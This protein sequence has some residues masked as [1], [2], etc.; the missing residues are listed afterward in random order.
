MEHA[1]PKLRI[2]L[3]LDSMTIPSWFGRMLEIINSSDYA[4][5]ELVVL[6]TARKHY[7]LPKVLNFANQVLYQV[8]CRIEPLVFRVSPDAFVRRDLFD[9]IDKNTPVVRAEPVQTRHSRR[10]EPRDVE[11]IRSYDIDVLIRGGSKILRGDILKAAR[12]GVWSFHH[13]DNLRYRG[14]PPGFWE[15]FEQNPVTGTILQILTEDLDNGVVLARSYSATDMLSVNRNCNAIYWKSLSM[16]PR[17]LR[18]LHEYGED[19]FFSNVKAFNARPSFY[20]YRMY[21]SPT[22]L[23]FIR[24]ILRHIWKLTRLAV[25]VLF[26][27]KQWI[28]MYSPGAQISASFRK[29]KHLIPPRDRFWADP[30]VVSRNGMYYIFIEELIYREN[31]GFI[32]VIEMDGK[33][34]W[35]GPTKVLEQPYH[36]SY[37]FVF[38][39]DGSFYMVPETKANKTIELYKC[40]EFPS[41]WEK[42]KVLMNDVNAVDA[43]LFHHGDKWWMFVNIV[44][45]RGASTH[46]ELFLFYADTPLSEKWISHPMN[47]VISDA[48]RARPAGGI[49]E[50]NGRIYRPSQIMLHRY[51]WGFNINEILVL[52]ETDYVETLVQDI[53]PEWDSRVV[54]MHSFSCCDGLVVCDGLRKRLRI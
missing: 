37:P 9:V 23:Q 53:H 21:T 20:A 25:S 11:K 1:K 26:F 42:H 6:N 2:G 31:K 49:F 28:L 43:T 4:S 8:Y 27:R 36:L 12:F 24:L 14:S 48:R 22:N 51:G 5:I 18:E 34:N 16:L 54:G 39:Y 30:C 40:V 35:S 29:F 44:E 7:D 47:P 19:R 15:V 13:G 17:K 45:N 38:E 32:S 3:L 52:S 10:F 41:K 50:H 46:D 33:G